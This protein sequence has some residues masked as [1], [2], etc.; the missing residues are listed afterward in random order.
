MWSHEFLVEK[1][2]FDFIKTVSLGIFIISEA[3]FCMGSSY[4]GCNEKLFLL[5]VL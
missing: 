5:S 4:N 2:E 3:V 1:N